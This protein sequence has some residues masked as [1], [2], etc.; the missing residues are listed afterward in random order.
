[1]PR[2]LVWIRDR[3]PGFEID[4]LARIDG[5]KRLC[6]QDFAGGP[7]EHVEVAIAIGPDEHL[8]WLAVP[9]HV[10]QHLLVDAVI[11]VEIVWVPLVE[12]AC[13]AGVRIAR[14]NARRPLV[15][16]GPEIGIPRAG[17]A[18]A[19]IDQV[20]LGIVGDPPPHGAAAD[21]PCVRRPARDA[22]I[23]A[24]VRRVE[25][26]EVRADQHVP[27]RARAVGGPDDMAVL[28]VERLDPAA[29][30]E[31]AARIADQNLVL[32][33]ERR[34]RDGLADID[35][36]DL[37][38][39][40]GLSGAGI[41]GEGVVVERIEIDPS[42]GEGGAAVDDVAAGDPLRGRLRF[43][44]KSPLHGR[45][46]LGEIKC[47]ENVGIGGHDIHRSTDHERCRFLTLVH[48]QRKGE[49]Y[50]EILDVLGGDFGQLAVAGGGIVLGRHGPLA[51][52]R[53]SRC[54]RWGDSRSA[55]LGS[56]RQHRTD[57]Q[58]RTMRAR[59]DR[60]ALGA[61]GRVHG[62]KEP[63]TPAP[64]SRAISASVPAH[65]G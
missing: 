24:L 25:R 18:G 5:T 22:E 57:K 28:G 46:G 29:H 26:L 12:P 58:G 1:M 55:C 3:A 20:Q 7:V 60:S 64:S 30:P 11:V 40:D 54:R 19:M 6:R 51:I 17:I 39:P 61:H 13:G 15:V 52:I 53:R 10:E 14:E 8:A 36:A 32:Y 27:I 47:I 56:C 2:F 45:A 62:P 59:A 63:P 4:A 9:A 48:A 42:V 65:S 31:L 21:L 35:V 49:R 50:L 23:R 41:D 37:R 33:D 34:H 38:V 16:A 43:G 44:L